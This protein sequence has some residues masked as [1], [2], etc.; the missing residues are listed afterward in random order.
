MYRSTP[1]CFEL[2][3]DCYILYVIQSFQSGNQA[4][5][6]HIGYGLRFVDVEVIQLGQDRK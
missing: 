4:I 5:A 6:C 3:N 2:N 1:I